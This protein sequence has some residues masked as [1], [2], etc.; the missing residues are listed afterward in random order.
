MELRVQRKKN[1]DIWGQLIFN[2][3]A[4]TIQWGK[5]LP[6][7]QMVLAQQNIHMQKNEVDPFFTP[8]TKS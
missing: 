2:N 7:Q 8:R 5:E 6:F 4:K 1:H 3:S